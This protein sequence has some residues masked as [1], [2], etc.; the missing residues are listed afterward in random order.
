M[1]TDMV[2]GKKYNLL[3]NPANTLLDQPRREDRKTEKY[4]KKTQEGLS[5]YMIDK[6]DHED[7]KKNHHIKA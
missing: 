4:K 2:K 1:V 3:R 7:I 5:L 6:H